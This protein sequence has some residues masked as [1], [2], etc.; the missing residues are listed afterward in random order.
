MNST[1]KQVHLIIFGN[2]Q[3][4]GYRYFAEKVS[5]QLN[6][7]GYVKNLPDGNVEAVLVGSDEQ[8]LSAISKLKLGPS[9]GYV[10]DVKITYT[11]DSVQD[12]NGFSI[13][14]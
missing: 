6:I 5:R 4:V 10:S 9:S 1:S 14:F 7:K 3:G 2:V 12:F 11:T 13:R 8:I